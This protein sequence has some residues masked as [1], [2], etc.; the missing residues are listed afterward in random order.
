MHEPVASYEPLWWPPAKMVGHHLAPF[1]ASRAGVE[2]LE[3]PDD[4]PSGALALAVEL[5]RGALGALTTTPLAAL[6]DAGEH[7]DR[8]D[9]LMSSDPVVVAPEDTLG[10]V[11]E[12]LLERGTTAAIVTE[13]GHVIG[14][15]TSGDLVRASAMRVHPSDGRARLWMTAEPVT[16]SPKT[17]VDTAMRLAREHGVSHLPV[18]DDGGPVGLLRLDDT[19]RRSETP[20]GLG[21]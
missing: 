7:G 10:E 15:L 9:E 20:I 18:V 8:V 5:D 16:V 6:D 13:Y 1:L 11:A 3:R 21:F 12:R 2:S 19:M 17:S 4:P 14:I